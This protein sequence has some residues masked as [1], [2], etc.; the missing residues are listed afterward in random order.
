MPSQGPAEDR[1]EIGLLCFAERFGRLEIDRNR[2]DEINEELVSSR[3]SPAQDILELSNIRSRYWTS[4]ATYKHLD[5]ILG[6]WSDSSDDLRKKRGKPSGQ[7]IL[8]DEWPVLAA[9]NNARQQL[10]SCSLL[11]SIGIKDFRLDDGLDDLQEAVS[12][13]LENA[14]EQDRIVSRQVVARL[15]LRQVLVEL[16]PPSWG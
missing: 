10:G 1:D 15:L 12:K 4:K 9:S 13:D 5:G 16:R 2:G 11:V 14:L 3:I 8:L 7:L 6:V